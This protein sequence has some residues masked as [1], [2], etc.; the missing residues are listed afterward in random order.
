[1]L[2]SHLNNAEI[3]RCHEDSRKYAV[4][5]KSIVNGTSSSPAQI[6]DNV[7]KTVVPCLDDKKCPTEVVSR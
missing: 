7:N 6:F 4:G 3:C 1:M 2:F 5:G